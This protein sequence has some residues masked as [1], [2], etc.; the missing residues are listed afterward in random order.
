MVLGFELVS[1]KLHLGLE[2]AGNSVPQGANLTERLRRRDQQREFAAL[3]FT[4]WVSNQAGAPGALLQRM[5]D[6]QANPVAPESPPRAPVKVESN[7]TVRLARERALPNKVNFLVLADS[8]E[9]NREIVCFGT[10]P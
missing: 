2:I 4:V 8:F 1:L 6:T 5:E 10:N 3:P 9:R 7:R